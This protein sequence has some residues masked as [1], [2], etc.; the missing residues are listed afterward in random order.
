MIAGA[1]G[2]TEQARAEAGTARALGYHAVLLG[3]GAMKGAGEDELI[4]AGVLQ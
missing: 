1:I 3:L 4:S 2:R